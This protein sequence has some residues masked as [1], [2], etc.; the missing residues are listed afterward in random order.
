M[1]RPW[2][3]PKLWRRAYPPRVRRN[4]GEG[5]RPLEK[6]HRRNH[7]VSN[8]S[9]WSP[10]HRPLLLPL[11]LPLQLYLRESSLASTP[12][13]RAL[14]PGFARPHH[15]ALEHP[16]RGKTLELPVKPG[17]KL[18]PGYLHPSLLSSYLTTLLYPAFLEL[19]WAKSILDHRKAMSGQRERI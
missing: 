1:P 15:P 7:L 18:D 2:S 3:V 17:P 8:R 12:K 6:A 5:L 4:D 10:S 13:L 11:P 19:E 14:G 16:K 9:L